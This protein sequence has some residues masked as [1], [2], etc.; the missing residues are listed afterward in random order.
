MARISERVDCRD[1]KEVRDLGETKEIEAGFQ[2]ANKVVT[3]WE[4]QKTHS[5]INRAYGLLREFIAVEYSGRVLLRRRHRAQI[6]GG[7][8]TN[9]G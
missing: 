2:L 3:W 7:R 4:T 8:S 6:G 5:V 9:E 1:S